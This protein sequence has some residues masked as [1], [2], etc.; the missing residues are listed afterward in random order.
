MLSED[1][2]RNFAELSQVEREGFDYSVQATR[3]ASR[4]AIIAPHG[5]GIEPGTSELARAIAGWS[6]SCYTFEG[7][8]KSGNELLHI[9]STLFDEPKC[10]S[11]VQSSYS[12]L[13]LH[14]YQGQQPITYV[15]GA[16]GKL[17]AQLKQS[18][19]AAGF[20]VRPAPAG[21]SGSQPHNV[22]NRGMS[23]AGAQLELTE[24]LR[25][26]MFR[27]LKRQ[28]RK[29]STRLFHDFVDAVRKALA[30]ASK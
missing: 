29:Y 26:S 24:A 10:I 8:K 5:G 18:L 4:I 23:G 17:Q 27:G 3:R 6:Y 20:E 30:A 28:E 22:C 16:D 7:L 14:G 21:V 15:G 19:D 13:A 11:L 9:T 2:Y 25:L 1:W 12:V